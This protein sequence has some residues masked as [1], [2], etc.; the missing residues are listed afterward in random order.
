MSELVPKEKWEDLISP[1]RRG[2]SLSYISKIERAIDAGLYDAAINYAWDLL[3][4]DLRLKVEAYG[5]DIFISV[6]D[7]IKHHETGSTLQE[8]WRDVQDYKLLSGCLKLNLISRTA[9]R[10]L[11]F[12]LSVRNHESAAH[13]IDEEE[14]LDRATAISC[15][16]DAVRFVLS[17]ELPEPGFN[18]KSLADNLKARDLSSEVEVI[19]EQLKHLSSEQCNS[20]LGMMV[21]LFIGGTTQIKKN[22]SLFIKQIWQ[23]A[24]NEAKRKIGEKYARFSSE[25]ETDKKSEVFGLLSLV[26]GIGLIPP[27]L[28]KILF[29][30]AARE[31][32]AA[33]FGWENY[34]EEIAPARQLA[35]LGV[36]CPDD[37]LDE[38][39]VAYLVSYMGNYYG[40]SRGAQPYLEEL[41]SRFSLRHWKG[42]MTAIRKS[43]QVQSE[44][45]NSKPFSRLQVLCSEMLPALVS[46][47]DKRDCEFIINKSRREVIEAFGKD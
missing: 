41:K 5:V 44:M 20:A 39:I 32:I 12:W 28:R 15:L 6:E 9:F 30:K 31:L 22:V 34:N 42:I 33:H 45:N 26:D 35:E 43:D 10:H 11:S 23:N 7:G 8:R 40:V 24:S 37:A 21:S 47:R 3:V 16:R 25:G 18:L 2:L 19:E 27:G 46:A 13:P 14:E 38:F 4:N 36:D 1:I 17:R 29:S